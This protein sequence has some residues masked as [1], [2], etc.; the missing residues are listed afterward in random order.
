M[1]Y[2]SAVINTYLKNRVQNQDRGM[3]HN[4]AGSIFATGNILIP[5]ILNPVAIITSPPTA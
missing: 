2:P 3:A 5:Q 4:N 1:K